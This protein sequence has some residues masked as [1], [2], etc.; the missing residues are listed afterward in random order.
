[1]CVCAL[2][3]AGFCLLRPKSKPGRLNVRQDVPNRKK[4]LAP[5][6]SKS[7]SNGARRVDGR[8]KKY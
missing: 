1:M 3:G 6:E 5:V 4:Q 7:P 2:S 8:A